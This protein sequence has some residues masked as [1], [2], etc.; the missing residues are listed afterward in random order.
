[1]E[2]DCHE[3]IQHWQGFRQNNYLA[4]LNNAGHYFSILVGPI[5]KMVRIL[6]CLPGQS[7]FSEKNK[8]IH[9]YIGDLVFGG[10]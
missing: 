2:N 3:Q 1:L 8:E 4:A 7:L 10:G 6:V 5:V 9:Q